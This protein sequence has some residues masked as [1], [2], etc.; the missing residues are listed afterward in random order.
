MLKKKN[1]RTQSTLVPD[2]PRNARHAFTIQDS[3]F[4]S[5]QHPLMSQSHWL[6]RDNINLLETPHA[7]H[8]MRCQR[9]RL[10]YVRKLKTDFFSK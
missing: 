2:S 7:L 10:N 8:I 9:S 3:F 4:G 6:L 1:K 5:L